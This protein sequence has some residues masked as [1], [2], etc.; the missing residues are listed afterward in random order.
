N[1]AAIPLKGVQ[2]LAFNVSDF[3]NGKK[4][5]IAF[6]Q[7]LILTKL[8]NSHISA[9]IESTFKINYEN[10]KSIMFSSAGA[11]IDGSWRNKIGEEAETM[12]KSYII[13]L[14]LNGH[15]IE[16]MIDRQARPAEF[17]PEY[18][19]ISNIDDYK[20]V[21]LTNKKSILFSHEPDIVFVDKS[22][23]PI[24]VIE[25]KGG[26]DP[27]G[28]LERLGA[29]KKSFDQAR[30]QSKNVITILAV[31]CITREM[32]MRLSDDKLINFIFNLTSIINDMDKR[33]EFLVKIRE[34]IDA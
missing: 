24:A 27:A 13:R 15:L 23:Q 18:D 30:R 17:Q 32:D 12:I 29:I 33:E 34:I 11:T 20:G 31:S 21:K 14:C 3:E 26:A 6:N 4:D 28:A 25:I 19:Y 10:I 22:A 16:S 1:V 2:Y 7:A 8:F 5:K 9:I